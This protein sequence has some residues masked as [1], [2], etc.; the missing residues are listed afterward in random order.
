[1]CKSNSWHVEPDS[2]GFRVVDDAGT[3]PPS[4]Q[5]AAPTDAIYDAIDILTTT[6]AD[7]RECHTRASA[8]DDWTGEDE[9]KAE[10]DRIL[11][12]VA[13]LRAQPAAA[14][15]IPVESALEHGART[16]AAQAGQDGDGFIHWLVG[17]GLVEM[18]L[19][20]FGRPAAATVP[21]DEREAFVAW[22]AREMPAGTVIG[23]PAW[24]APRI[25]RAALAAPAAPSEAENTLAQI[26]GLFHIGTQARQPGILMVNIENAIR[27]SWCLSVVESVLSVPV[28]PEPE[29]DGVWGEESLLNWGADQQG[30]AEHFKAALAE[31]QRHTAPAVQAAPQEPIGHYDL[32][33]SAG[34]RGYI[35]EYFPKR[36]HR[37][38]FT[39]YISE[40]LAADF[41]CALAKHLAA[42]SP[43][44]QAAQQATV[45]ESLQVAT[46]QAQ[47]TDDERCGP[48]TLESE[49]RFRHEHDLRNTPGYAGSLLSRRTEQAL[50]APQA[51]EDARPVAPLEVFSKGPWLFLE[52][53]QGFTGADLDAAAFVAYRDHAAPQPAAQAAPS[54]LADAVQFACDVLAE[55]YAKH[56]TK[57]GPFAS[58]AQLANVRLRSALT[59]QGASHER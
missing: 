9:A 18:A 51:R 21:P 19:S 54:E 59:T 4:G 11:R 3:Q 52:T 44:V 20:H 28:P 14:M 5:S 46:P 2:S 33:T 29:G 25:L 7:L 36:L 27:R 49:L 8:P 26:Y 22:L 24:W 31:F 40:T 30:Y 43:A 6:A 48:V 16:I 37:H 55:L 38:D 45:K 56:Q 41:A 1:M 39:R 15:P 58:Q 53:G 17:G 35:A 42:T 23:D 12:C 10:Y 32:G 57:I 47:E 50:A 13:A 34:G